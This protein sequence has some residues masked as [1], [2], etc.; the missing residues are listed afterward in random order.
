MPGCSPHLAAARRAVRTGASWSSI[1]QLGS[2]SGHGLVEEFDG[3]RRLLEDLGYLEGWQLA[4]RGQR[5]RG[6]Y[7]ESDLLL[8]E[9]LSRVCSTV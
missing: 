4:E 8:T 3:I 7:N 2:C 5:L 9:S 1:D 6:I